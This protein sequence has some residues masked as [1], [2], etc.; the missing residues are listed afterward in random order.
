MLSVQLLRFVYDMQT[1]TKKK[2]R[3]SITFPLTID[4]RPFV[5]PRD[6]V[7]PP[8]DTQATENAKVVCHPIVLS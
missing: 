8:N 5:E 3:D 6:P 1:L 7:D 4:L 2:V